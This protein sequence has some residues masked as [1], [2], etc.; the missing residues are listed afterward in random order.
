MVSSS[1]EKTLLQMSHWLALLYQV[2]EFF[3]A[4]EMDAGLTMCNF[5]IQMIQHM[6]NWQ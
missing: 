5:K 3:Y 1:A 6:C 4:V 2:T